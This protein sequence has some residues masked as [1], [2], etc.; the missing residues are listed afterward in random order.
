MPHAYD[1]GPVIWVLVL[2][3]GLGFG[4]R[5]GREGGRAEALEGILFLFFF[6][7]VAVAIGV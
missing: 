3:I 1:H 4:E 6:G 5:G 2:G 7:F